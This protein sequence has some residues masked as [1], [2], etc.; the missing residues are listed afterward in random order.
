MAS[1]FWLARAAFENLKKQR[2]G[3]STFNENPPS[4]QLDLT[5][6][7]ISRPGRSIED[8]K[9][10]EAVSGLSTSVP[11]SGK[12]TN[13]LCLIISKLLSSF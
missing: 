2:V 7:L 13:L 6:S 10:K 3:I 1:G 9:S 11:S 12:F 8:Y 5:R 4:F